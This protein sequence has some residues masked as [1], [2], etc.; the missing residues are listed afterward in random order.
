M[1]QYKIQSRIEKIR[2]LVLKETEDK[3][4]KIFIRCKI[5]RKNW[6]FHSVCGDFEK[7]IPLLLVLEEWTYFIR[8]HTSITENAKRRT[9]DLTYIENITSNNST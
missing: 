7:G 8:S 4:Q 6:T 2:N 1:Y 9:F 3:P 5:L